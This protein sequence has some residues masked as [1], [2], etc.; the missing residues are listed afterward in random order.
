MKMQENMG[1]LLNEFLP[2]YDKISGDSKKELE[3]SCFV[4]VFQEGEIL[5]A[6]KEECSGLFLVRKGRVR[7]YVMTEEGKEVTLFRLIERDLCIFSASCTMKNIDF[8]VYVSAQT[9]VE[10]IRI[11]AKLYEKISQTE[12]AVASFTNEIISSKMS[13]V[14][15]VL[16][17]ILFKSFDKR[18]ACFLLEESN[19]EGTNH[20]LI[21]HEQIASHLGSAREVV[22]RMLKYFVKEGMVEAGRGSITLLDPVAIRRLADS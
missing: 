19:M 8:S 14:M 11:P 22:S 20:I 4:A 1:N 3:N 21:T 16:E 15:W 10:A 6:G 9:Y 13:D 2:F 18:L 7:A 17:Q 5:H 12:I